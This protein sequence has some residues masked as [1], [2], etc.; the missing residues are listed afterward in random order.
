MKLARAIRGKTEE[1]IAAVLADA[2]PAD[3]AHLVYEL[4]NAEPHFS[5]QRVARMRDMT[6]QTVI[7]LIRT[8]QIKPVHRPLPKQ[9]WRIP[10]STLRRWDE[11][12]LVNH[13]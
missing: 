12:T 8:G 6:A 4:S 1:E 7:K 11:T 3:V 10:L 5:A 2:Q 9:G 13:S